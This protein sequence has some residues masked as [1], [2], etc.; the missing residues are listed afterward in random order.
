M[1]TVKKEI[2]LEPAVSRLPGL[3]YPING[4]VD[5]Y[6]GNYGYLISDVILPDNIASAITYQTDRDINISNIKTV[7]NGQIV[8][9]ETDNIF[10]YY[11]DGFYRVL[12]CV[13]QFD[14]KIINDNDYWLVSEDY[15]TNFIKNNDNN[16]AESKSYFDGEYCIYNNA[17]Y[18]AIVDMFPNAD[19]YYSTETP[20]GSNQWA[21]V[22][23]ILFNTNTLT[24]SNK[25]I[26]DEN[27]CIIDNE[28]QNILSFIDEDTKKKIYTIKYK[29]GNLIVYSTIY[30][31]EYYLSVDGNN[32]YAINGNTKTFNNNDNVTIE[33][34]NFDILPYIICYDEIVNVTLLIKSFFRNTNVFS[35]IQNRSNT[36]VFISLY[37]NNTLFNPTWYIIVENHKKFLTYRSLNQWYYFFKE[38]ISFRGDYNS[39]EEAYTSTSDMIIGDDLV[40]YQNLDEEFKEKGGILTYNWIC[41]S[42][43]SRVKVD[44][45]ITGEDVPEF[46][47]YPE[48]KEW[49]DWFEKYNDTCSTE[50]DV[51]DTDYC[52]CQT[53]KKRG[54][55]DMYD[56]LTKTYTE[57]MIY[58]G[59][60]GCASLNIP[61]YIGVN[62]DNIGESSIFSKEWIAGKTY[63]K[64][65]SD[66]S[67][68]EGKYNDNEERTLFE[69]TVI[70]NDKVYKLSNDAKNGGFKFDDVYKEIN[71]EEQDWRELFKDYVTMNYTDE[72][73]VVISAM[74]ESKLK[75]LVRYKKSYTYDGQTELEGI[76]PDDV[77]SGSTKDNPIDLEMLYIINAPK[78]ISTNDDGTTWGNI[79]T[80]IEYSKDNGETWDDLGNSYIIPVGSN[81]I[82]ITYY[83]GGNLNEDNEYRN[84]GSGVKYVDIYNL[85]EHIEQYNINISGK[86]SNEYLRY[87]EFVY[88]TN[89]IEIS[90]LNNTPSE[91][92]MSSIEYRRKDTNEDYIDSNLIREEY[93][94]GS[95]SNPI[96]KSDVYIDRGS[97]AAIEKY[98]KLG[99]VKTFEDLEQYGNGFYTIKSNS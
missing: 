78:S 92:I 14:N 72:K 81:Q 27:G 17:V 58:T 49:I 41:D 82:K 71:F 76:L 50:Q 83:M 94:F 53:Y 45:T 62:I 87:Y 30:D 34:I 64:S 84:D 22:S 35:K 8:T 28:Y 2:L 67:Y 47:Y 48:M 65:E 32:F 69:N 90:S 23:F 74:T 55:K 3:I 18:K 36:D 21:K 7:F 39:C 75:S 56:W 43:I 57:K 54:G 13:S 93:K 20:E 42:V 60:T 85:E 79:I 91:V 51:C 95:S 10:R 70:Y 52:I 4:S 80:K 12:K 63:P 11:I 73:Q 9:L 24:L 40:Y 37:I 89:L 15:Y 6:N 33:V 5:E 88:D 59:S 1:E 29:E 86:S 38:Y 25:N 77:K 97:S 68:E 31:G 61:L 19:G 44:E 96:V 66:L 99:E 26:K 46:M 98:L 16:Y